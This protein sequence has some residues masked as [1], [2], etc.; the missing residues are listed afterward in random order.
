MYFMALAVDYDGTLADEGFVKAKTIEAL[1][2][3]KESGRKLILVTGRVLEDL[4]DIFDRLDLFDI[5]VAENGALLYTPQTENQRLLAEPP[6][7]GFVEQLKSYGVTPLYRGHVIVA[8]EE[9]QEKIVLEIIRDM[10]LELKIIFNK[11]SV[12]ILPSGTNKLTG[13]TAAL[14]ELSLS[15]H[16]VIGIGD[17]E[18]DHSFLHAV[19]LGVAVAN[20]YE[21]VKESAGWV[22]KGESG[23]GV[24]EVIDQLLKD[25]TALVSKVRHK[26]TVGIDR[27]GQLLKLNPVDRVLIAG[28]SGVGKSTLATAL[29]EEMAANGFQ[30][31]IFDPEGD[32]ENL[33]NAITIGEIKSPPSKKQVMDILRDPTRNVIV[34]TLGIELSE[35]PSF[36]IQLSPQ[37]ISLKANCGRPHWLIIDEA[38]HLIPAAKESIISLPKEGVILIT[39]HPNEIAVETLK[40]LNVVISLGPHAWDILE[41]VSQIIGESL[42]DFSDQTPSENELLIWQRTPTSMI[43]I[44]KAKQPKQEHKRHTRKYAEGDLSEEFC[45][46]FRGPNNALHLKAQNLIIFLQISE[47]ID[48]ATWMYHLKRNDYSDWFRTHIKDNALAE[49]AKQIEQDTSLSANQSKQA[50]ANLVKERYTAPASAK[51]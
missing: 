31:C 22:T 4:K 13:L 36:F 11:G 15:T 7:E 12:M 50:I 39:V 8:T 9:P 45:F 27:Q 29:T 24:K 25:E 28:S 38:H 5:V 2:T 42:S 44:L 30:F 16:N 46:Y 23:Q 43:K 34:S 26:I 6:P 20:A 49:A 35:R 51:D 41:Q 33:E 3:F 37:L 47:G 17:A 48:D 1:I 40:A 14:K 10:G 32:H 19:G 21:A 18:N